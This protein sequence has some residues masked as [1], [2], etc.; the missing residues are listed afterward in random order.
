MSGGEASERRTNRAGPGEKVDPERVRLAPMTR[1]MFEAYCK[2][3]EN[4]PDLYLDP[5]KYVPFQY[6]EAWINRYLRRIADLGR[7]QLAILYGDE[8]VGEIVLKNIEPKTCA[9]MGLTLKNAAWKDRG[10]GTRAE[11]LA[12][13]YVFH[14]L[15][16][17]VLYA[18]SIQT[19]T[20]SQHVLEKVGFT[21]VREDSD[22]KYYEIR[23]DAPRAEPE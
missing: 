8:I 6:S 14:E 3:Y 22:F 19:N 16:V 4:D 23:R 17:P 2:E 12:V 15:E 13:D 20:R 5:A 9:T 10:I 1:A 21:F 7:V 18:D 11:R